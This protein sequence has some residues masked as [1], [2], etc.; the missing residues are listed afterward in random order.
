MAKKLRK[1]DQQKMEEAITAVRK[2]VMGTCK[3]SKIFEVPRST[4]HRLSNEKY[5]DPHEAAKTK[6]GRPVVLG[7]QLEK[8]LVQYCLKMEHSFFDLTRG[9]LRRMALDLAIRNEL[10]HP[11]SDKG[12]GK[13]WLKLF[14]QRHKHGL[15]A[16]KPTGT[17]IQRKQG[18]TK[19]NVYAFHAKYASVMEEHNFTPDRIWN[20]DE[21][22]LSIVQSKEPEVIRLRGQRQIASITSAERASLITVI[23]SMSAGGSYI[24]P[25]VIFPRN[26]LSSALGKGKPPG[27]IV[28][29]HPSGWVQSH[30]FTQWF[31]HFIQHTK[32]TAEAP[33]L[34]ILD[35]QYSH[36]RNIDVIDLAHENHVTII[37]LPP[38]SSHKMLPLNKTFMESLKVYYREEIRV[39]QRQQQRPVT[40][41]D[42][43]EL[44][45][46]AYMICQTALIAIN[47]F[48]CTGIYPVNRDI[49]NDSDYLEAEHRKLT[50]LTVITAVKTTSTPPA[51]LDTRESS[52]ILSSPDT[53][54]TSP[55]C[56]AWSDTPAM[57]RPKNDRVQSIEKTKKKNESKKGKEQRKREVIKANKPPAHKKRK[58][59][60]KADEESDDDAWSMISLA[61]SEEYSDL[62]IPNGALPVQTDAEC[63]FCGEKYSSDRRREMWIQCNKCGE[64]AHEACSAHEKGIYVCH[65]CS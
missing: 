38:H 42:V 49:F 56:S 50:S 46:R 9:D 30:I 60:V 47:G 59:T 4:L 5:G 12:A 43:M 17:S 57:V 26:N 15:S 6:M 18:F 53:V 52:P 14:L 36:T 63:I 16:R 23:V 34:L 31:Q 48:R 33:V 55:G 8:E 11:F 21:S 58:T 13:K 20:V 61:D 41:F 3:A 7:F 27:S 62:D 2:N 51:I 24:P 37:S 10:S 54:D 22:G 28:T 32:P 35:G 45:G 65:F 40:A 25:L 19:E 64:W 44:F 1:Y 39:F 29:V